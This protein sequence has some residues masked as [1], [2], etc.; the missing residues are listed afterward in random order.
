MLNS[1]LDRKPQKIIL[2]RLIYKDSSNNL[3]FTTDKKIIEEQSIKHF[4]TLGYTETELNSIIYYRTLEDLPT[5]W[6]QIYQPSA[7]FNSSIMS[8]LT[9]EITPHELDTILTSLPNN[10]SPGPSKIT[11]EDLKH[12]GPNTKNMLLNIFNHC[13]KF[14]KI[15]TNWKQALVYPI[16]KPKDFDCLLNNTRPIT[17][18]ETPRKLLVKILTNRLNKILSTN[19]VLQPNNRAGLI[20]QSTLQPI[21]YLQHLIEQSQL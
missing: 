1:I 12:L 4:Q 11:Y 14:G 18:L 16:P 9:S 13:I 3:N 8:P 21:Q 15:P 10:K 7:H 19:Q 6:Q 17:L 5:N 20:G 2:D